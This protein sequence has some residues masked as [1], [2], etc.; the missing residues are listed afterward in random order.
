[1]KEENFYQKNIEDIFPVFKSSRKGITQ[2]NAEKYLKIYGKNELREEEKTPLWKIILS[3][4]TSPLI[5]VLLVAALISFFVGEHIDAITILAIVVLNAIL[6]FVEDIKAE[7]AIRS[8]KKIA[9]TKSRVIREGKERMIDSRELVPGDVVIIEAGDKVPADIRL[10]ESNNLRVD[11]AIL[12]GESI[13]IL[14]DEKRIAE[15][16]EIFAQKN[17]CFMGTLVV[18]GWGKGLVVKTG[19]STQIGKIARLTQTIGKE[20]TPLQK[21]LSVLAKQLG[22][23]CIVISS[24][25]ALAGIFFGKPPLEMFLVGISLAVAAI[26]EGLPAVVTITLALGVRSMVK[27]HVLIRRLHSSESL[28]SVTVICTDKTGTLTQNRMVVRKIITDEEQIDVSGEGYK[29][30]GQFFINGKE[31]KPLFFNHLKKLFTSSLIC[32]HSTIEEKDGEWILIGEP[33]EGSLAALAKKSGITLP[34]YRLLTE[35]SFN[36]I[37]KRMTVV[38]EGKER[39]AWV[40]GAPE[41][42]IPRSSFVEG[43]EGLKEM[44][45]SKKEEWLNKAKSLAKGGLRTLAIAYR[46]LDKSIPLKEEEVEKDLVITG[47]V[48]II[49]PARAEVKEAIKKT[50]KAGIDVYM[51]TGDAALTAKAV[52]DEI[53]L[54]TKDVMEGK[55]LEKLTDEELKKAFTR[56]KIFARVMPEHKLRIVKLLQGEGHIVAMTGDGVN[57]APALKQADVG[58]AMGLRGTDVAR[59]ASDVILTDD[60]FV[61]IV[62]GVEEGRHQYFNIQKF[63]RFLLS[64]NV[65]EI[66]AI[67]INVL[68]NAP[69]ILLPAQILWVNLVTDGLTATALGIEPAEKGIMEKP[70]ISPKTRIL[71]KQALFVILSLGILIAMGTLFF[72]HYFLEIS[73]EKARTMAFTGIVILEMVNIWNFRSLRMPLAKIG[74]FSNPW[75][76]GAWLLSIG[77]QIAV[78]YVP[79]MQKMF[80]TTALSLNDWLFMIIISLPI[81]VI[82]EIIK[83]LLFQRS[84]LSQGILKRG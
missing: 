52:A 80:H 77:L 54:E 48:G 37:R 20:K 32:N 27:R 10:F 83:L 65:G 33:T 18:D 72:F 41:V 12:T 74:L 76:I 75:F 66:I 34:P 58:I 44:N 45:K 70:P 23:T 84:S 29:P 53:G 9:V 26:P 47:I 21:K 73:I 11:E 7:K 8:L 49:D 61:S 5:I 30:Q 39:V 68:M 15:K 69:L 64:S 38:T 81:F 50:K 67:F 79:F 55:E 6:G 25:I 3:Q 2:E 13:A 43:K 35:F 17:M 78:V 36:S 62:A 24:I 46:K 16:R 40:K 22:I 4:F 82:P 57:D 42:I 19:M 31:I 60:N 51:V 14:K 1:M 71:N 56:T 63:V 59:E 28:G